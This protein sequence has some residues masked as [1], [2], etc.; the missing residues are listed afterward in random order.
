MQ[1]KQNQSRLESFSVVNFSKI[2]SDVPSH[3]IWTDLE[4]PLHK[5]NFC[6]F[7]TFLLQSPHGFLNLQGECSGVSS[8]N[9]SE[10]RCKVCLRRIC[11]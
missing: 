4:H 1:A 3:L 2:L 11:V 5:I 10:I 6:A 7:V 8:S 9:D